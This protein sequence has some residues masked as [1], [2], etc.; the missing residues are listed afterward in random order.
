MGSMIA[1]N[2]VHRRFKYWSAQIKDLNQYFLR[3][4]DSKAGKKDTLG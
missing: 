3:F 2:V 4:Q 1:I